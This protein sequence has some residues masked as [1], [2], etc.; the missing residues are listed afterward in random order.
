MGCKATTLGELSVDG[1]HYG[2]AAPAVDFDEKLPEYLRI[3]DIDD[4]GSLNRSDRKS[5]SDP[6]AKNFMLK[7]G[8][9]VFARTGNSTGR[10]YFYDERDGS[11]A[12][13]GFLIKFSLDSQKVNPRFVKYYVQ[14]PAYWSWI[15]SFSTGST[16]KNI[17]AKT[18][19]SCPIVLPERR[20]QDGIV[21]VCDSISEK[22]RINNQL[23]DYLAA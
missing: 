7:P 15:S 11:F 23:N 20:V 19:A 18:F 3:T 6:N 16:R 1:G 5:V 4:D 9:I 21:E 8:D 22:I 17:N 10:N 13:A 14:S 12:F 2:I